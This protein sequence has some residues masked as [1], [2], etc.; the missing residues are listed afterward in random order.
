MLG[1]LVKVKGF[2]E[3]PL[4]AGLPKLGLEGLHV[5]VVD[6]RCHLQVRGGQG[7]RFIMFVMSTS[8][9]YITCSSNAGCV[10]NQM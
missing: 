10:T 9:F 1:Q 7:Q 4:L 6:I 2:I 5:K 3:G 8:L